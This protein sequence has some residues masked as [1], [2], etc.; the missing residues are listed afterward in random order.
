MST[1]GGSEGTGGEDESLICGFGPRRARSDSQPSLGGDEDGRAVP[2]PDGGGTDGEAALQR[3]LIC[4]WNDG[5]R[6]TYATESTAGEHPGDGGGGARRPDPDGGH[7]HGHGPSPSFAGPTT[8]VPTKTDDGRSGPPMRRVG[9]SSS[10]SGSIGSLASEDAIVLMSSL[11]AASSHDD[12]PD[13]GDDKVVG[14]VFR[15]RLSM[16]YDAI[17]RDLEIE[18]D[19]GWA[20]ASMPNLHRTGSGRRAGD[21]EGLKS[22]FQRADGGLD[23]SVT[24][25]MMMM[26]QQQQPPPQRGHSGG[27]VRPQDVPPG[28]TPGAMRSASPGGGASDASPPPEPERPQPRPLPRPRLIIKGVSFSDASPGDAPDADADAP[29]AAADAPPRREYFRRMS[30]ETEALCVIAEDDSS[31]GGASAASSPRRGGSRTVPGVSFPHARSMARQLSGR[32]AGR[33]KGPRRGLREFDRFRR[34]L[35]A[36][37]VRVD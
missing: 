37:F 31:D 36:A 7:R 10:L 1:G 24:T 30:S 26:E 5:T 35:F 29:P 4:G 21:P 13:G 19:A 11:G 23:T 14:R 2:P 18:K 34:R 15:N 16:D 3:S 22:S 8:R 28:D 6:S 12:P 17:P 33:E 20:A 9:S 32:E 27:G 25:K